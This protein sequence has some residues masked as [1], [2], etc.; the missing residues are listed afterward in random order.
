MVKRRV[1]RLYQCALACGLVLF[2]PLILLVK[3]TR[4]EAKRWSESDHPRDN[5]HVKPHSRW[6]GYFYL[7]A[8]FLS[9]FGLLDDVFDLI[10][11]RWFGASR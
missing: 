5:P 10:F 4:F 1:P 9:T 11:D 8:L 6:L 7:A 2:W 3:K